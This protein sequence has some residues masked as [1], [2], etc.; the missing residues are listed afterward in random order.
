M[1]I[2]L[3]ID[4]YNLIRCSG[5]L[6]RLDIKQ[7]RQARQ[8]LIDSLAEY[9]KHREHRITV[10]FDGARAPFFL[11]RRDRIKGIAIEF[12]REGESADSLIKQMAKKERE[13][14]VVVSSD[15]EVARFS[16]AQGAA[17][18]TAGAF[19]KKLLPHLSPRPKEPVWES[20][21]PP[22]PTKGKKKGPAKRLPRRERK[23][24]QKLRKL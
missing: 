14:A 22:H 21:D 16:R 13:R 10:V 6:S 20:A 4:G 2:H 9:K 23:N 18:L 7:M 8:R 11:P 3:I 15:Q 5:I 17:T 19:E 1:A 12:S 24:R